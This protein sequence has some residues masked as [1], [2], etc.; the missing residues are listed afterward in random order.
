[1]KG[2]TAGIGLLALLVFLTAFFPGAGA[3]ETIPR[4][5]P[6]QLLGIL[7]DPALIILDARLAKDWR[8]SDSKIKGAVR[9]DPH[10]VGSWIRNYS[11]KQKIVV[12]CS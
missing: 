2:K 5:S 3:E 7:D 4:T 6:E 9:V 12:Y 8:E 11:A 10:D 1:M